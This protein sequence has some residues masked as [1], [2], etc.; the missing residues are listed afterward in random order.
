M[1]HHIDMITQDTALG[2]TVGDTRGVGDM[3]IAIELSKQA[4]QK[5]GELPTYSVLTLMHQR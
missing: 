4:E 3:Q 5:W 1:H 2:R